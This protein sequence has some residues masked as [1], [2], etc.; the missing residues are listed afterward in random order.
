M[1][2]KQ[3]GKAVV[4]TRGYSC[5]I[6]VAMIAKT[7]NSVADG[8]SVEIISDDVL[9]KKE[10][11]QWCFETGNIMNSVIINNET[12]RIE[13]IKGKGYKPQSLYDFITF[14]LLGVQLHIRKLFVS[15][16]KKDTTR[17]LITFVSVA[18]GMRAHYW[19]QSTHPD[20]DYVLLPVPNDITSHCGVVMGLP[21]LTQ[22]KELFELLRNNNFKVEDIYIKHKYTYHSVH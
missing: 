22:A 15:L 3:E 4:D 11:E 12:I 9:M 5:P 14:F 6:S 10:L 13:V 16:F 21:T 20:W 19:L 18:E 2:K 17:C 1:T 8:S 7:M